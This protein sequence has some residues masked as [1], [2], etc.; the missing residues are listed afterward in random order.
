M[1]SLHLEHLENFVTVVVDDLGGDFAHRGFL[2]WPAGG[3]VK[4]RPG[5]LINLG[6]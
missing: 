3:A 4:A 2:E 1:P 5:C 6:P